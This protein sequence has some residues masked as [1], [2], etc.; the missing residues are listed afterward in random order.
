MME[1]EEVKRLKEFIHSN[2]NSPDL[3]LKVLC[4][5]YIIQL[6]RSGELVPYTEIKLTPEE[7]TKY[8]VKA[9]KN[10]KYA[11]DFYL[12]TP[13]LELLSDGELCTDYIKG[14]YYFA[15]NP[16]FDEQNRS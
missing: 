10:V 14:K 1:I 4:V 5:Q 7:Y 13:N 15:I 11:I 3:D 12:S 6:L 8:S 16:E 9:N 2:I